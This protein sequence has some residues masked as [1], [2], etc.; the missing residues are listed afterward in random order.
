MIG[1]INHITKFLSNVKFGKN[2]MKKGQN[3]N[4]I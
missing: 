3:D 4:F 2:V 1:F